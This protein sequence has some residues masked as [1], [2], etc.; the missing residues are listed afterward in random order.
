MAIVSSK[1]FA[2]NQNKYVE[3]MLPEQMFV[4]RDNQVFIVN[5]NIEQQVCLDPDD[6]LHRA[7]TIDELREKIHK[8]IHKLFANE[9]ISNSGSL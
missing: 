9:S 3:L 6:D 8:R 1:K 7:I 2:T 5:A 4:Q